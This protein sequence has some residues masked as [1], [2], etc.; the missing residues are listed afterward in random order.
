MSKLLATRFGG[1]YLYGMLFVALS[2]AIRVMLFVKAFD[3]LEPSPAALLR[4]FATGFFYDVVAGSFFVVL[5]TLYLMF[6]PERLF[7]HAL[8]RWFFQGIFFLALYL[9][10]FDGVS[11][12]IFWDEFG[13]RYNFIAVDYLVY[14]QEVIGNIRQS[15]PVP[16]LLLVILV[17]TGVIFFF[18]GRHLAPSLAATST[19]RQRAI[20][21]LAILA[22][23]VIFYLG[24]DH[25]LAESI[26]N[27]YHAELAKNGIYALFSAFL[28]NELE[29]D[30]FYLRHEEREVFARTRALLTT[31]NATPASQDPLDITRSVR[32]EGPEKRLNVIYLTIESMSA[33]Y[34]GLFGNRSGLTPNLDR[35]ARESLTF[36]NVYATGTRTDRGMESIVLSVPPTPGRSKVK[37]PNNEELF[38]VG[39][40]FQ[41]RGYDT[42]FIYGG[43]GYFDNMN[44]FFGHNGF[45]VVD[46]THL[47]P[48]EITMENVWGVADEDL[49]RRTIKEADRA[50]GAGLPFFH[51]VMT[52]SNHRP[53]T[54][55]DGRIDIPSPGGREGGVKYTDWAIGDFLKQARSRPWFKD[56][57]F[58]IMAD[59]CAGSAGKT[60]LPV[61]RYHIPVM[62]HSPGH[63]PPRFEDLLTS[64][65]DITPTVLGLLNWSYES[66]FFGQDILRSTPEG[67]RA[68]IGTYQKLGLITGDRLT[69][70]SPLQ[71]SSFYRFER[72]VGR[73]RQELLSEV[74][75][76]GLQNAIA[77]YQSANIMRLQGMDKK[78]P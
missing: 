46:R 63:I 57:L 75:G 72:G 35:L 77:L 11:E 14:T 51:F 48:S 3:V 33:E 34:L 39:F 65:I 68:F 9:L 74:D 27:R 32:Y 40:L 23:P 45:G 26:R 12:W 62:I 24:V 7:R 15:Y 66:R 22:A 21:G 43:Y 25:S 58:V 4:I 8:H 28:N 5:F 56:T 70:L 52:T 47:D 78:I 38:S 29:Y 61:A 2:C 31:P 6:L 54:Y 36:T 73:E 37:R 59:H 18:V 60:E 67:R 55:P 13:V 53:F 19:F 17:I 50:H 69:V 20:H 71:K 16:L 49:F 44:Y 1:L 64:Q 10:V 76:V 30:R 42:R 41:K